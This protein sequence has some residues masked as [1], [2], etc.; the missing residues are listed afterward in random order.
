MFN[1][2]QE[3]YNNLRR[4][5]IL[6]FHSFESCPNLYHLYHS[7]RTRDTNNNLIREGEGTEGIR[8]RNECEKIF[9]ILLLL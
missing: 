9:T 4:V 6:L 8:F 5:P 3:K 1:L 7:I 2:T